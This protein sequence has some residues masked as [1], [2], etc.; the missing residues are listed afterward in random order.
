MSCQT[1]QGTLRF[2]HPFLR[3]LQNRK[4]LKYNRPPRNGR[5]SERTAETAPEQFPPI[6][7]KIGGHTRITTTQCRKL[8]ALISQCTFSSGR[9]W[10]LHPHARRFNP[11]LCHSLRRRISAGIRSKT[12]RRNGGICILTRFLN[13]PRVKNHTR[14][15]IAL[16]FW[17]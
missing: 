16:Y 11:P 3:I 12:P 14:S 5:P 6:S 8:R 9:R 7:A 10:D 13:L 17:T 4:L 2:Y 15:F 1:K